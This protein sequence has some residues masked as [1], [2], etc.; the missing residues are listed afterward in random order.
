MIR[1]TIVVVWCLILDLVKK[2]LIVIIISFT[3][4][5]I[6]HLIYVPNFICGKKSILYPE[7]THSCLMFK[8]YDHCILWIILGF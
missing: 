8:S 4:T 7:T 1:H 3:Y 5:N 6:D 2:L